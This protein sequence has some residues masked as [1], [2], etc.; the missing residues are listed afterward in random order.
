MISLTV[1]GRI[2]QVDVEPD[3]PLLGVLRD[4]LARTGTKFGCGAA[5]CGACTVHLTT[6][7]GKP[8]PVRACTL[9]RAHVGHG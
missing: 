1:N 4:T 9:P 8:M 7:G 5:Q 3:T 2:H 6:A